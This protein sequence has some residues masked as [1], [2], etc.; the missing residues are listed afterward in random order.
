MQ[1]QAGHADRP[2]IGDIEFRNHVAGPHLFLLDNLVDAI[3]RCAGNAL[4]L[5]FLHPV[6]CRLR[7]QALIEQ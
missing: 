1:R 3:H 5:Q 4:C 6:L 2:E 7:G